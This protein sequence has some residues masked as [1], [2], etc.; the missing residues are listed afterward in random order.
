MHCLALLTKPRTWKS[1]KN[2]QIVLCGHTVWYVGR[3][4]KVERRGLVTMRVDGV[5]RYQELELDLY[6]TTEGVLPGMW[7]LFRSN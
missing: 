1:T 4:A 2:K 7:L 6:G 3:I 5:S